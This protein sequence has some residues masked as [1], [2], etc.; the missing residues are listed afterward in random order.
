MI[1]ILFLAANP[2]DM[3]PLQVD[4]E[5]RAIDAELQSSAL[6]NSFT[7]HSHWAVRADDLQ[8]LLLR[9]RP[10]I[11]HFS[12]HGSAASELVVQ[13]DTGQAAPIPATALS[14]LFR[15]LKDNVRCVVLNA[16]YSE[17]QARAIAEHIDVVIGMADEI[18]D[19]NAIHFAAAFYRA[20]AENKD[21]QTAF[22]LGCNAIQLSEDRA[23]DHAVPQLLARPGVEPAQVSVGAGLLHSADHYVWAFL[24]VVAIF[25]VFYFAAQM[26]LRWLPV[27]PSFFTSS[28]QLIAAAFVVVSVLG[29]LGS[30]WGRTA[31]RT[32][33]ERITNRY[34]RLQHTRSLF[35]ASAL[36]AVVFATG[37]YVVTPRLAAQSAAAG[38]AA[39]EDGQR[40]AALDAFRQAARMEPDN[41]CHHFNLGLAYELGLGPNN[42]QLAIQAYE[43]ALGLDEHFLPTYNNLG[44][45]YLKNPT[46]LEAAQGLLQAGVNQLESMAGGSG[47]CAVAVD[48]QMLHRGVFL[49]NL[50]H[51]YLLGGSLAAAGRRLDEAAQALAAYDQIA[52]GA[53][54]IYW[55]E[56]HRLRA[57]VLAAGGLCAASQSAW[58]DSEGFA[59]SIPGSEPCQD[60]GG[61]GN[62]QCADAERWIAE[63]EEALA[64]RCDSL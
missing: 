63:A 15:L 5:N 62:P 17:S 43:R 33:W 8:K 1:K 9:H 10:H 45:L 18:G 23:G 49:K 2:L 61:L 19:K 46:T 52:P 7:L 36:L 20:L 41:A 40:N 44:R 56:L 57:L 22:D 4:E 35:L 55:A 21:V 58:L 60:H 27:D 53:T 11:V 47:A 51:A 50:G 12:G 13:D 28:A 54:A 24:T 32:L 14:E 25:V 3:A 48:Q 29:G 26:V 31:V 30:E 16:C 34:P 38:L 37:F 42:E 59:R 64:Q 6:R 39:L